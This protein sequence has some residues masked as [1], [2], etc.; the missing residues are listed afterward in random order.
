MV[1]AYSD[2]WIH[3]TQALSIRHNVFGCLEGIFAFGQLYVL[4][5]RVTDPL[6]LHLCGLPPMDLL[7]EIFHAWQSAGF[8]AIECLRRCTTVTNDFKYEPGPDSLRD[9]FSPRYVKER[10]VAVVAR[11]LHEMLN[12]QP[13]AAAVIHRLLDS[14]AGS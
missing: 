14:R 4:A 11:E 2:N 10:K 12:P 13:K 3:K 1:C 7:D 5:S 6:L 9:R 8:D